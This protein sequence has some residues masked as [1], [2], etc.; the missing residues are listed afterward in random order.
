M[1]HHA[2]MR[3]RSVRG[4]AC[5]PICAWWHAN[6]CE[7]CGMPT[8]LIYLEKNEKRRKSPPLAALD[9]SKGKHS[10]NKS[11]VEDGERRRV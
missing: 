1:Q 6:L 9:L 5:Q 2:Q 7:W 10:E 11:E 3:A 8:S 4:V